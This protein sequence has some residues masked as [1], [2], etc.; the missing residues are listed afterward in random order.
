MQHKPKSNEKKIRT[1]KQK[2][3]AERTESKKKNRRG[4]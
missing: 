4:I 1:N 2:K 3:Y